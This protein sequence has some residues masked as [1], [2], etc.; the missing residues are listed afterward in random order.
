MDDP[1]KKFLYLLIS[2]NL[3]FLIYVLAVGYYNRLAVDDYAYIGVLRKFG[4]NSPFTYWYFNW[5]GRFVPQYFLNIMYLIYQVTQNL[6]FYPALLALL[7][8]YS[9]FRIL[10]YYF[11]LPKIFLLNFSILLFSALFLTT[12]EISTFYWLVAS[13]MYFGGI[14]FALLGVSFILKKN[15]KLI[16]YF[17]IALSFLY[18]G[19]SS[20]HMGILVSFILGAVNLINFYQ[21]RYDW[22]AFIGEPINKKLLAA[23]FFGT[24]A[25]LLM[26]FSPGTSLR[27]DQTQHVNNLAELLKAT[28]DATLFVCG[29]IFYKLPYFL[30]FIPLFLFLGSQLNVIRLN[31]RFTFIRLMISAGVGLLIFIFVSNLPFAYVAGRAGPLR[32]YVYVNAVSVILMFFVFTYVGFLYKRMRKKI[33]GAAVV[34]MI[35]LFCC[36]FYTFWKEL[37]LLKKYSLTDRH[38]IQILNQYKKENRTQPVF[39]KPLYHPDYFTI[40]DMWRSVTHTDKFPSEISDMPVMI[41]ELNLVPDWRN[42]HLKAGLDLDFDVYLAPTDE[43]NDNK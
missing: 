10:E 41:N 30:V 17:I 2:F 27:M 11:S 43:R 7:F 12:L 9:I 34:S 20:E 31:H 22:R 36:L 29:H 13:V 38:R 35:L 14:L 3:L 18:A 33:Y 24:A 21:T 4:F 5:Q 32:S 1:K 42:G 8:I 28:I 15:H 40:T 23:F 16:D 6:I 26:I 25:F 39:V 19:T 37:P